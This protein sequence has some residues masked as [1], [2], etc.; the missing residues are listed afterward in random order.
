MAALL[1]ASRGAHATLLGREAHALLVGRGEPSVDNWTFQL[2][3][4]VPSTTFTHLFLFSVS[5][6]SDLLCLYISETLFF[7]FPN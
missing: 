2:F 3:Y 7:S 5:P 6:L 4:K 1:V